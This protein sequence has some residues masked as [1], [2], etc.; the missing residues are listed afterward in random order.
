MVDH[1]KKKRGF[2]SRNPKNVIVKFSDLSKKFESGAKITIEDL[3]K[4]NLVKKV[5]VK[6]GVKILGP[7]D[8]KKEF[9]FGEKILVSKS[10]S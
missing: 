2:T 6:R 10:V 7:K 5:E 3:I 8:G 4:N 1:M 9:S